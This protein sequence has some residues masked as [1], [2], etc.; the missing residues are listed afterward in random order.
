MEGMKYVNLIEIST[1][2]IE[3]QGDENGKLVVPINT[4][5]CHTTFLADDTLP[6]VL[7]THL[8]TAWFCWPVTH[9][10]VF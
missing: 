7:I 10:C 6:C 4:F 3:I 9:N 8:C 1:V 5:V 2:V